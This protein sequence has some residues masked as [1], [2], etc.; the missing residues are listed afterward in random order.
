VGVN[1]HSRTQFPLQTDNIAP[2][3]GFAYQA[4]KRMVVRGA[5]GIF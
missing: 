1:G 4:A 2:R 3:L 5:F